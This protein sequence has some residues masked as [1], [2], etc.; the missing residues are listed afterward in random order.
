MKCV[1]LEHREGLE[2]GLVV[3]RSWGCLK[4]LAWFPSIVFVDVPNS[5]PYTKRMWAWW[6][7]DLA[8]CGE[9]MVTFLS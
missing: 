6:F 8:L 4:T 1:E 9:T 2:K 3:T 7:R 5:I